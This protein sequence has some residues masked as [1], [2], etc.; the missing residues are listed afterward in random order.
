V[1][2][3]SKEK[4]LYGGCLIKGATDENLGNLSDANINTYE[5]TLKN[6]QQKFRKP[7]HIIIAHN[8]WTNLNSLKNSIEMARELKKKW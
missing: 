7:R 4:V 3:F 2:W 5:A 6:V 1:V 8:D